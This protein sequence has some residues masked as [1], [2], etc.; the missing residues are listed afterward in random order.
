[1]KINR[2]RFLQL[3]AGGAAGTLVAKNSFSLN[4]PGEEAGN[5]AL[6]G[7]VSGTD[8]AASARKAVEI[9]GG[10]K[11]FVKPGEKVLIKPN[12]SWDK[13]PEQAAT[14]NPAVVTA[15]IE[16]VREAGAEEI[17]VADNTC[18]NAQNSYRRSGIKEAAEEAGAD[19]P[20]V[21][22]ND[23]EE[24]NIK[25]EVLTKWKIYRPA[26]KADRIINLPVAKHHGL[27][28]V[29]LSM[30]NLMG[31]IGGRRNLLH[32][33][34]G[35]SIVD[36]TAYFKPDLIILDAVRILTANGPQ[37]GTLDDVQVKNIIAASTDPVRIDA[38]GISL[39]GDREPFNREY[40]SKYL[41]IAEDRNLG[42]SNFR[43]S[44]FRKVKLG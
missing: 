20:Y 19:V 39:F 44:G 14:T 38:F 8:P 17:T 5:E 32:Q 28:G 18:N 22:K 30:K 16:M 34:L 13:K 35:T 12:I 43:S 27:S 7:V 1:M 26:L 36:L 42:S 6:L 31:L 3:I 24:I 2:R 21:R 40:V 25:G 37:G 23:F 4:L 15:V 10:M 11:K 33:K 41:R 9:L 29:S